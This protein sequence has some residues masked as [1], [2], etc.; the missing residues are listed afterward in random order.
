M[1]GLSRQEKNELA[2]S[3]VVKVLNDSATSGLNFHVGRVHIN[4]AS[5][6]T[7]R[8][9]V[10][11][12]NILV[13]YGKSATMAYYNPGTDILQTQAIAGDV[14][15]DGR[16]LLLHEST[17]ALID[18]FHEDEGVTRH[19][20]EL[21]AYV[22]Q[23]AYTLRSDPGYSLAD[24]GTA[25]SSFFKAVIATCKANGLDKASGNGK[26]LEGVQLEALRLLLVALPDVNYGKIDK[27][28][29]VDADGLYKVTGIKLKLK[30][31]ED[32]SMRS[33]S[34]AYETYPD[35][36]DEYLQRT[37]QQQMQSGNMRAA[38]DRIIELRNNFA[39][40]SAAKAKELY[41]RLVARKKGDRIS[42]LFYGRLS[43]AGRNLLLIVLKSRT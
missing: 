2:K 32:V 42:E 1:A 24:D 13:V 36:S 11:K 37:L 41:L 17:H 21:A 15:I 4:G 30:S 26:R 9:H 6:G 7:I 19:F 5:Y 23:Y 31:V 16:A 20:G 22:A 33:S 28:E 3:T 8:A 12:D 27:D 18:I 38:A 43:T 29:L 35:P 14:D 25:W 10:E 34:V 40:C 39:R